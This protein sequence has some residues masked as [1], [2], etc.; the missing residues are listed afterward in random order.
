MES[1]LVNARIIRERRGSGA[2]LLL[3]LSALLLFLSILRPGLSVTVGGETLPGVYRL[4]DVL[5]SA[6]AVRAAASELLCEDVEVGNIWAVHPRLC[7]GGYQTDTR[8][9]QRALLD[10]I[11]GIAYLCGVKV[12]GELIGWVYDP[13]ALGEVLDAMLAEQVTPDTVQAYFAQE[14]T[15]EYSYAP[16][17]AAYDMMEVSAALRDCLA[18]EV[19]R[20]APAPH[21][22]A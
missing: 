11:P 22:A 17:A 6:Q 10:Q 18:V 4:S 16:E 14:V 20:I 13:S 5:R 21:T 7:A 8:A 15:M 12:D 19:V 3:C 2:A 1:V 9:L